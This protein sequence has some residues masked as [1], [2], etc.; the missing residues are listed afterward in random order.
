MKKLFFLFILT[1]LFV[2]SCGGGK[3]SGTDADSDQYEPEDLSCEL[4]CDDAE[5]DDPDTDT[6]E[7]EDLD[8]YDCNGESDDSDSDTY[9]PEDLDCYDCNG[10]SDDPDT[11]PDEDTPEAFDTSKVEWNG[12]VGTVSVTGDEL[13]TYTLTTNAKLRESGDPQQRTVSE[14]AGS[15]ILRSGN[16]MLD[17]LFALAITELNENKVSAISDY[18]MS[19][20]DQ[21]PCDCFETGANWHYVW[22]RDTAY[23]VHSAIAFLEP[24]KS[25]N[26]LKFKIS[27][28]KSAAGGGNTQI[29]Q[30]TGSGGSWPVS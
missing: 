22:T 14:T 6:Y 24:Q 5:S 1:A 4:E 20:G 25:K 9:E 26:S 10:E 18:S 12:K 2:F 11:T 7:P 13:R 17:A 28:R 27:A 30:D 16:T 15:P 23:A 19:N 21:V 29:V 8:C 3:G